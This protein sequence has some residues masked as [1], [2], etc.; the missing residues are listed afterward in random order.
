V[1]KQRSAVTV[2]LQGCL[3]FFTYKSDIMATT[4][5]YGWIYDKQG[6][7]RAVNPP[8]RATTVTGY[9]N[10]GESHDLLA[11]TPVRKHTKTATG[12]IPDSVGYPGF[13]QN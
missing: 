4:K 10:K 8:V 11:L 13:P 12:K 1:V 6:N 7:K 2:I 3:L 5:Q 9:R